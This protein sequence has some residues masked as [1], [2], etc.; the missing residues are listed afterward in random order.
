M[1]I[2]GVI[3]A[4]IIIGIIIFIH[5]FGHYIVGKFSGTSVSRFSL[6]W[7]PKLFSFKRKETHYQLSWIPFIGG[8][9]R[10]PGMEGESAELTEEEKSDIKKYNLKTFEDARTWQKF[11]VFIGGVGLQIVICI[12]ILTLVIALWG[13][14][15]N[16]V[17]VGQV[18]PNSPAETAGVKQYDVI[19][20]V[21][22][23][24]VES[25]EGLIV[26]LSDKADKEVALTISRKNEE[27]QIM[28]IPEY[29]KEQK[30]ALIGIGIGESL[31]FMDLGKA[32]MRWHD[33]IFG[34][35]I[36][37]ANM[38]MLIL[39]I[40]WL[41]ITGGLSLKMAAGP[42]GIIAETTKAIGLGFH[43]TLFFFIMININLAIINMIPFPALDGG[44]VLFLSI[45]KIFR[46]KIKPKV[47]EIITLVGFAFLIILIIYISFND[48]IRL[49]KQKQLK[50]EKADQAEVNK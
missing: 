11:L 12:L 19:L 46:F 28:I 8:Y 3:L 15:I 45:E 10:I 27:V 31:D 2:L 20:K 21:D 38:I 4:I 44:H 43:Y 39:K 1:G 29:S 25:S 18:I 14:P 22:K 6:G 41:L 24:K 16:K 40:M 7:G 47:K 17:F 50:T 48:I 23:E 49:T 35:L 33:Y 36:L 5:E 30:R 26:A 42:I 37:T 13:K 9:V 34:G 32:G